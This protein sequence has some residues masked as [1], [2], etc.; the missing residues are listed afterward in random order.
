MNWLKTT[1]G[2]PNF[3]KTNGRNLWLIIVAAASMWYFLTSVF[4]CENT[5]LLIATVF[6]RNGREGT[7]TIK[8]GNL[9]SVYYVTGVSG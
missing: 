9:N 4:C 3:S 7:L 5:G 2:A 8:S 1:P 6:C